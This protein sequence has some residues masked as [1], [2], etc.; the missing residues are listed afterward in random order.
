MESSVRCNNGTDGA[1]K[2]VSAILMDWA[3]QCAGVLIDGDFAH[4]VAPKIRFLISN[5]V[6]LTY[7]IA[8][9]SRD[10]QSDA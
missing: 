7:R 5:Q 3:R 10:P 4:T 8:V 6:S 1:R 2:V 9:V